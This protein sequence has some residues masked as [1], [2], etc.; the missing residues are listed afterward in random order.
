MHPHL[1]PLM[2]RAHQEELRAAAASARRATARSG[3]VAPTVRRTLRRR[4]AL[5]GL[6]PSMLRRGLVR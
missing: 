5:R 6:R 3:S 4:I 1:T 2:A